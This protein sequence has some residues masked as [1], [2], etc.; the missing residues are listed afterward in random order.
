MTSRRGRPV[1]PLLLTTEERLIMDA[2][3]KDASTPDK[4]V[5]RIK[6]VEA[7]ATGLTNREVARRLHVSEAT[8][9]RWRNRF[10]AHGIQGLYDTPHRLP[11]RGRPKKELNLTER[12]RKTL[13]SIA[14]S[15]EASP[16]RRLR[17]SVILASASGSTNRQ[18]AQFFGVSEHSVG[19]WREKY[20]A[21][22]LKA[23]YGDGRSAMG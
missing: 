18:V 23:I 5:T 3:L 12:E 4:V 9:G 16:L 1:E 2:M 7:C 8:I 22:R 19:R 21:C 15:D 17:S 20:I 13:E 11:R 6:A 14:R 10:I